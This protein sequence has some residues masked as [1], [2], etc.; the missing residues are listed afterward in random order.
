MVTIESKKKNIRA[1]GSIAADP[2]VVCR[3]KK[4]EKGRNLAVPFEG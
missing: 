4:G 3:E 1:A 2:A